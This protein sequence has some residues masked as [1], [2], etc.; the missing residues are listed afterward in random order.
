ME[1]GI[2]AVDTRMASVD[3]LYYAEDDAQNINSSANT[4]NGPEDGIQATHLR[5]L[6]ERAPEGESKP[7]GSGTQQPASAQFPPR[8][9]DSRSQ[10]SRQTTSKQVKLSNAFKHVRKAGEWLIPL[11]LSESQR[12]SRVPAQEHMVAGCQSG[13]PNE[14]GKQMDPVLET[15]GKEKNS[16]EDSIENNERQED[17]D[18]S[19]MRDEGLSTSRH[20][21]KTS[22]IL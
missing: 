3:A 12:H 21:Q 10:Y 22:T 16:L 4:L 13:H 17:Y 11:N 2:Q 18:R 8:A 20:L 9:Q 14:D 19:L 6:C 7:Y 5:M 15:L 1:H